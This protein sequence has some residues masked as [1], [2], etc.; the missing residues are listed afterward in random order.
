VGDHPDN[1]LNTFRSAAM[2][3]IYKI[4]LQAGQ[5]FRLGAMQGPARFAG[6]SSYNSSFAAQGRHH[7]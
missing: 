7:G 4:T 1:N 5:I 2:P 6:R 3:D